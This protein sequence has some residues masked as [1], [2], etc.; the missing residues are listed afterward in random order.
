MTNPTQPAT[1][2]EPDTL[3]AVHQKLTGHL[4]SDTGCVLIWRHEGDAKDHRYEYEIGSENYEV[5]P[6]R[7]ISEEEHDRLLESDRLF[8]LFKE[9]EQKKWEGW[10]EKMTGEAHD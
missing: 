9:Q 1:L 5:L 7:V 10:H 6:V 8:K 3:W 2:N 4:A